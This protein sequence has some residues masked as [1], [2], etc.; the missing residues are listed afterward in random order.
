MADIYREVNSEAGLREYDGI[1]KPKY[2]NRFELYPKLYEPCKYRLTEIKYGRARS[3]CVEL[4]YYDKPVERYEIRNYKNRVEVLVYEIASGRPI[5]YIPDT[6][7]IV[8]SISSFF[9]ELLT[10]MFRTRDYNDK[11][12]LRQINENQPIK[13]KMKMK[14][15]EELKT[16]YRKVERASIF[17]P[18]KNCFVKEKHA[19]EYIHKH[20][21]SKEEVEASTI[22]AMSWCRPLV[23]NE[24]SEKVV[25]EVFISSKMSD[26]LCIRIWRNI[27]KYLEEQGFKPLD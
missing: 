23:Y 16:L 20:K 11:T 15:L 24:R 14:H 10:F 21:L 19:A 13:M 18:R 27:I 6:D 4:C 7:V 22:M 26:R 25:A 2:G 3:I 9:D 1:S 17:N 8:S 12:V 5:K